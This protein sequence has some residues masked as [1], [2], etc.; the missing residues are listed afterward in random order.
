MKRMIALLL[1]A[2]CCCHSALAARITVKEQ[3]IHSLPQQ[4][5][6]QQSLLQRSLLQ[7]S[8]LRLRKAYYCKERRNL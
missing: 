3:V 1:V 7:R 8:P 2:H 4:S 5:L 6:L